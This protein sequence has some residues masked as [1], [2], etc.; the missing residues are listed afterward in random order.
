MIEFGII[1]RIMSNSLSVNTKTKEQI[2]TSVEISMMMLPLSILL[3]GQILAIFFFLC[4]VIIFNVRS[5]RK[6]NTKNKI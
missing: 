5:I 6:G 1:Q 4:E 2:F 3:T